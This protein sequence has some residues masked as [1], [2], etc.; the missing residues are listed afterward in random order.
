[1]RISFEMWETFALPLAIHHSQEVDDDPSWSEFAILIGPLAVSFQWKNDGPGRKRREDKT[2][3]GEKTNDGPVT[4]TNAFTPEPELD[5]TL[6]WDNEGIGVRV[7]EKSKPKCAETA[8]SM[9]ER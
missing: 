2:L 1:M 9:A 8:S 4:T 5:Y 6:F 7:R 3:F